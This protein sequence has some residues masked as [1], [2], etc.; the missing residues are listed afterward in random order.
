VV[1]QIEKATG[2]RFTVFTVSRYRAAAEGCH[3]RAQT[4]V[5]GAAEA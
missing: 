2:Q 5:D 4:P 3:T 1:E